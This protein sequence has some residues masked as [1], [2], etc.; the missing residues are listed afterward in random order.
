[1][2]LLS[3]LLCMAAVFAPTVAA[4]SQ[5]VAVVVADGIC[6]SSVQEAAVAGL[7]AAAAGGT[8]V[9][10]GGAIL[11]RDAHCF[12]HSAPVTSNLPDRL[13]YVVMFPHGQLK[14]AGIYHTHT[15]GGHAQDFSAVDVDAHLQLGVPSYIGTLGYTG[16][17]LTVRSLTGGGRGHRM[18]VE[19]IGDFSYQSAESV[20]PD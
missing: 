16:C 6:Y 20:K 7:L 13:G 2:T 10:Y 5:P 15:P 14:L 18:R 4:S 9:E 11:Q 17:R 19:R 1:M 12:V 8:R 3:R